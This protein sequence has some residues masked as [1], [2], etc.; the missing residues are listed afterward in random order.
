M[1]PLK[2]LFFGAIGTIAETSDLQRDSFNAA[3]AQA[4]VDWHWSPD[5]Y[6]DLLKT[7]GGQARLL[8]YRDADPSRHNVTQALIE[9]IHTAKTSYYAESLAQGGLMPR[10]G[11]AQLVSMCLAAGIKLG[12]CT[13]TSLSNVGSIQLALAGQLPFDR[14]DTVVTIDKIARVKPAPDAYLYALAQL[15][16]G[17]HEAVAIEDSPVSIS[18]AKAAGI[19]CIATPGATTKGQD[20]SN[21]DA[22]M[23]DVAGITISQ[24]NAFLAGKTSLA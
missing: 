12:W 11:V 23:P 18:A 5:T 15:G 4:G 13:S 8:L 1:Q 16:I 21:A 14:F 9:Q 6:R 22:I 20:F 19:F 3:F 10:P 7:N 17:P 24:L 2:A